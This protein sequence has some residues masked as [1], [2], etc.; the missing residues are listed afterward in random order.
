MTV[1]VNHQ[2]A[3]GAASGTA[4]SR[5]SGL[6]RDSS[7]THSSDTFHKL[8]VQ[9]QSDSNDT[10]SSNT[11]GDSGS[12]AS[13]AA[14]NRG[15]S[16]KKSGTAPGGFSSTETHT[17]SRRK[18]CT[19]ESDRAA[20]A[21]IASSPDQST[22]ARWILSLISREG[23]AA[24]TNA[25]LN[26]QPS[27]KAPGQ[28]VA[29][30][31][32]TQVDNA[33]S[34]QAKLLDPLANPS[35]G[36]E[37]AV[38][39]V[40]QGTTDLAPFAELSLT[41]TA[42]PASAIHEMATKP[43]SSPAFAS[44]AASPSKSQADSDAGSKLQGTTEGNAISEM[45]VSDIDHSGDSSSNESASHQKAAFAVSKKKVEVGDPQSDNSAIRSDRGGDVL[46]AA[47]PPM[48]GRPGE[49]QRVRMSD[50]APAS[51]AP[52]PEP[53]STDPVKPFASSVGTIELQV[54]I[55]DDKQVGLR[56]V[57]RQGQVEVQMKS[58]DAQTAKA[59]SDNLPGLRTSLNENGWDVNSRVQ[60]RL[61]P[62]G[63]GS[64][65][66]ASTE[67]GSSPLAQFEPSSLS[68]RASLT[69][70]STA[71]DQQM[72]EAGDHFGSAQTLRAEPVSTSQMS[73]QSGTDSSS[74]QD[75]SRPD[76]DGSSG[77]NGQQTRNDGAGADSERQGRRSARDS[78]AW[79]ESIESNLTGSASRR[80]TTGATK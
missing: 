2:S 7:A 32:P 43:T 37:N 19:D 52:V 71:A 27:T 18:K 56:F 65:I 72:R 54:K 75:Q 66:A 61:S 60:D 73:Q 62:V 41:R 44:T 21:I 63:Q 51:A 13:G 53:A 77:R 47:A 30:A 46:R 68:A 20:T 23:S 39:G 33:S 4:G 45:R 26:A 1:V 38:S 17:T 12:D 76:R 48:A 59:L 57:E 70:L 67:R 9:D 25:E 5:P 36:A 69:P 16:D 10:A 40:T 22:A 42:T 55:A 6:S 64:Q 14:S 24:S 35:G 8:L 80:F 34:E 49:S 78:E 28:E 58:G 3:T 15:S 31:G 74:R 29:P 11:S 50:E 79:L